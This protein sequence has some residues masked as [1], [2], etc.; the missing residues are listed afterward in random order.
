MDGYR[1]ISRGLYSMAFI[2]LAVF[3]FMF[4]DV[5]TIQIDDMC[6]TTNYRA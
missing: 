5:S 6:G 1:G 2:S 4:I 3:H